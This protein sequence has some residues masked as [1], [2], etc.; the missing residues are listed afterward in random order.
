MAS[1]DALFGRLVKCTSLKE[2][3]ALLMVAYVIVNSIKVR[4]EFEA[5]NAGLTELVNRFEAEIEAIM[6]KA[7]ENKME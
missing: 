3:T 4:M 5:A 6:N 7:E 2:A 1:G